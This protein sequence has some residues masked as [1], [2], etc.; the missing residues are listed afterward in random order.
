M[1]AAGAQARQVVL[2]RFDRAVHP[3]LEIGLV[4]FR[5]RLFLYWAAS[6]TMVATPSPARTRARLPGSRMLNTTIGIWLSRH[7]A[8]ALASITR[9]EEHTSELQSLM[10]IS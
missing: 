9:S 6:A 1:R 5:H 7:S 2:E 4:I 10:R 8:T 3:A